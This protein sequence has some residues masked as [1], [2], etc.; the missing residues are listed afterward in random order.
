MTGQRTGR[1]ILA[2]VLGGAALLGL[3]VSFSCAPTPSGTQH[4]IHT[5]T[6]EGGLRLARVLLAEEQPTVSLAAPAPCTI[7]AARNEEVLLELGSLPRTTLRASGSGILLGSRELPHPAIRVLCHRDGEL[8]VN[9]S[10]YRGHVLLRRTPSGQL[11][12]INCVPVDHYLYSVLGSESYRSWPAAAL[13]AQALVARSYA[14]WRMAQRRDGDYDLHA[15]VAD[16]NYLGV[17]KETPEF[18]AAVDRTAG[19]VLLYQMK[20][21]RC[22]YHSTCGGQTEAVERAFPDPPLLPLSGAPCSFCTA[23]KHYHWRRPFSRAEVADALRRGGATLQ[24]VASI[25]VAQRTPGG[26]AQEVAVDT[27]EGRRLTLSGGDFRQRL[28][29]ARLPSTWFEVR[30]TAGGFEFDGRGWGHGVGLCQ[31]GSKGM[32]EA[33]YSAGSILEHYYPGAALQRVYTATGRLVEA[34]G[35]R[36]SSWSDLRPLTASSSLSSSSSFLRPGGAGV[37]DEDE[38]EDEDEAEKSTEQDAR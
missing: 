21:F 24:G 34:G 38:S 20:L 32:A 25:E 19:V 2:A 3:V 10:R 37:E 11:A 15:T 14:M 30:A 5:T 8:E 23:S 9:G 12:A 31:W 17:A 26:R 4:V 28:G 6:P 7:T 18:R 16:Q 27:T 36:N 29:P 1:H 35:E 22:Y 33:G 13:E